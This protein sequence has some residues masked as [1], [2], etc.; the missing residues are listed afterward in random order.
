[1]G[2][3]GSGRPRSYSRKDTVEDCLVLDMS[4]FVCNRL[5]RAG[6][7]KMGTLSWSNPATGEKVSS[8]GYAVDTLGASSLR[9]FYTFAR[10]GEAVKYSVPL[11]TTTPNYGGTRW[12]FLCPLASNRNLCNRRVAKLYLPPGGKYYGCRTCYDLTYTS[13]QE[14]DK[15]VAFLTKNPEAFL[16]AMK[17]PRTKDLHLALKVAFRLEL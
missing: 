14:H 12:W 5:V 4:L 15:R 2:G 17:S 7:S 1:M 9:L 11:A 10:T 13:C 6:F 16:A 3:P 8:C